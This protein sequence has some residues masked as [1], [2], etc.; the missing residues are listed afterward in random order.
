MPEK[1]ETIVILPLDE[2]H[3]FPD[4]PFTVRDDQAM[5][6]MA[7]ST[8]EYGVLTPITVRPREEGGYE[9]ISGHRRKHACE[10][11]GITEIPAIIRDCT[12]DEAIVMMVDS[13]LQRDSI[14]P[15][16]KAKAYKMKL[17]AIKR[18]GERTDLLSVEAQ[19][20]Q[21]S[22]TS[23]QLGQKLKKPTS[24]EMMASNSPDSSGQI[25]RIIRL[26]NLIPPLQKLVDDK[27]M[28]F[29]PAVEISYLTPE[30][31]K[32]LMET[33]ESEMATPSLSQAQRMRRMSKEGTLNE[34]SMLEIMIE[35]KKP[36][37][38]LDVTI[39]YDEIKKYFPKTYTPLQMKDGILSMLENVRQAQIRKKRNQQNR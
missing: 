1:N 29:T 19:E 31:Q 18:Q 14:L 12:R 15:S 30:E 24:R 35:Q 34:D 13:N 37:G 33:I 10:L 38:K 25:Q 28:G 21:G 17:E 23:A 9:I 16:E 26:N 7:E 32:L 5:R 27:K 4:H 2:L 6:D 3:D 8:R 22:S 20:D 11:S 36:E 39:P